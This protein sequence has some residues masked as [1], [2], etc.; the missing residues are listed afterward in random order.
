[1]TEQAKGNEAQAALA[2]SA[3]VSQDASSHSTGGPGA[4]DSDELEMRILAARAAELDTALTWNPRTAGSSE[5][6]WNG[7]D[8]T[9]TTFAAIAKELTRPAER[10]TS[11]HSH[12]H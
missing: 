6:N 5:L 12:K 10:P 9:S 1:M 8:E 2:A 7:S 3:A 11:D 4:Y